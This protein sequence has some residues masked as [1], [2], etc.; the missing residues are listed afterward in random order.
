MIP[1]SKSSVHLFLNLPCSHWPQRFLRSSLQFLKTSYYIYVGYKEMQKGWLIAHTAHLPLSWNILGSGQQQKEVQSLQAIGIFWNLNILSCTEI[2]NF[3]KY[4][5]AQKP[6]V[7]LG[8][9]FVLNRQ[10]LLAN[11]LASG[12]VFLFAFGPSTA[13]GSG[14]SCPSEVHSADQTTAPWPLYD[15]THHRWENKAAW[16]R[17][18][19]NVNLKMRFI[20]GYAQH[21]K[22]SWTKHR[23]S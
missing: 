7:F 16:E 3:S 15:L 6:V 12:L 20:L 11:G 1:H 10:S 8:F 22:W 23:R 9:F 13:C 17:P 21:R 14:S 19:W 4:P 5:H 2:K 18:H